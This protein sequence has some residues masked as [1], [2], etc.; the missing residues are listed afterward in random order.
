MEEPPALPDPALIAGDPVAILTAL[1]NPVRWCAMQMMA[2]GSSLMIEQLA[3]KVD[4]PMDGIGKHL[5][6]MRNAGVIEWT[7]GKDTRVNLYRIP[8]RFLRENRVVDFGF[9]RF[10]F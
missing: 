8:Q 10:Q 1:A 9:A 5:I 3:R 6:L 7:P 2:D 4:K